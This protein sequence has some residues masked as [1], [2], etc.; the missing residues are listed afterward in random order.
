MQQGATSK[1]VGAPRPEGNLA[2]NAR[3]LRSQVRADAT[4]SAARQF[5]RTEIDATAMELN[6]ILPGIT[7]Q[8]ALRAYKILRTRM[9]QR[10]AA[11][12]W[13][14][15]AITGTETGQGKT[16]TAINL[17]IALA[18]DPS[19]YVFLVDLDLQRP[20]IASYMGLK[21]DRGLGEYLTGD[22]SIDQ[23]IYDPGITR[24]AVIP[25]SRSLENSSE[26]LA[27]T[28]MMNLLSDLDSQIPRR[29]V[30]YDMPPVLMSDDVM[31][32]AP[33]IDGVA[34]VVAEG[35]T[36]RGSLERSKEIL[37]EMN[38]I[39]VILNR[40]AERSDSPYY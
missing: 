12:Q 2:A 1:G 9:L 21:F 18:Q 17:A 20:Q 11:N 6:C 25:N 30:I 36:T 16:L 19:T 33:H 5:Q 27:G 34:L 38:L 22:A 10:L 24:L 29:V 3:K 26:H 32:F 7:D 37:A 40:S 4:S 39:G 8:S 13:H 31:T 23:I 35:V 14:S 28:N 15:V